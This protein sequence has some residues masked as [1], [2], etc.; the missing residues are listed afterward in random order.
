MKYYNRDKG[1]INRF[2]LNSEYLRKDNMS[3]HKERMNRK[4]RVK[5]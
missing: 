1:L 4:C 2:Y 5:N 3:I